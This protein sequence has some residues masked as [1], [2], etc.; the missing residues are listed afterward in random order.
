MK[1]IL[2]LIAAVALSMP[3]FAQF[4]SG[5]FSLSKDNLYYGVRIGFTSASFSGDSEVAKET[6][7][8]VGMTLGGVVGL[9]VSSSIPLFVES[10]L[11]YSERGAKEGNLKVSHNNLE[12]PLLIKYG[13]KVHDDVAILPF[14]G[15][16]FAYGVSG[17]LKYEVGSEKVEVSAFDEDKWD[18]LKRANMG[19]KLGCGVEYNNL[20]LELGYQFGITDISKID[21]EVRSN[22]FFMNLGVNF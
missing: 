9:R 21:A 19:F 2:V 4:K 7:S 20:Y 3:S 13:F 8:K 1:K 12:I 22:A 5:G 10:G 15:P 17:K 11:Y 6:G 16:V 14:L 18:A